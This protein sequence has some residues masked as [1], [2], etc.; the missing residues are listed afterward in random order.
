MT[1]Q[2]WDIMRLRK[3]GYALSLLVTIPGLIV[4]IL[5]VMN[6]HGALNWGVDFTGGNFLHVRL[7]R[8]FDTGQV[9]EVV[10]RFA[11]GES[12]IQKAEKTPQEAFIRTRPLTLQ[13]KTQLLAALKDRFGA[14]TVLREDQVGPKV[15]Q[16][17]RSLAITSIIIGLALQVVYI[18]YRFK[19]IRYAL[20]ADIALVHDLLVV[21]GV[22]AMT[23]KEVNSSFVAVLL[24][25]LGYSMHDTIVVFD[26]IRENLALRTR[27]TFDRLVNRSLLEALVRSVNTSLTAILAIAAVYFFGGVTIRDFSFGLMVGILTG[28][29]SSTFTATALIVDWTHWAD[30]RAGRV[31]R[32]EEDVPPAAPPSRAPVLETA[33]PEGGSAR[34]ATGQGPRRHRSRR[35]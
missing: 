25:V 8:P 14:V 10:D 3:W 29:Y 13:G 33:T 20:S 30:R 22:F 4:L 21:V 26:R 2:L 5:N 18:S 15:G 31:V 12:V 35:R 11:T 1:L 9:R 16:E 32:V 23:R 28:T 19:S 6:G 24:T 27:E 17:L 7:E 34:T